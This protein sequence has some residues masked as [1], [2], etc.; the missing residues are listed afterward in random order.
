MTKSRVQA[1][2]VDTSKLRNIV[3]GSAIGL[4]AN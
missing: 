1:K 2:A 4:A 3:V